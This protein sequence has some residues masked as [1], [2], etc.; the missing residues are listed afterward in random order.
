[1]RVVHGSAA[2]SHRPRR[3]VL[4]IGNFDGVHIGHRAILRTVTDRARVLDGEAVVYTFDPH[5]RKVLQGAAA[6]ALLTT[7]EQKLELL[8]AAQI[9][10]VVLE[11][12]TA[13]FARTPPETFVRENIHARMG[14]LEVYVG[15]DFHYGRDREGSMR[16]LTELGPRLGFAVTIIPEV[17]MGSR[18][19]SSSR[20]RALLAEGAVE[21]AK[22]LLG[23]SY[24]VRGTVVAGDRRGRTLGFPTANLAPETEILPA[25]GVYAGR[26]RLL[27]GGSDPGAILGAVTNVGRRPTFKP[28]DPPLAE[29]H[30]L[31]WSG[32]LYGRRI[33]LTFETRLREE[34]RFSGP[35]ALREQIARDVAEGRRRLEAH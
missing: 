29:A 7:T 20:I 6:P 10:L 18:D 3:P 16:L 22:L 13:A 34:R 30:L 23:R 14:P 9:D 8:A 12:F 17:T 5:P 1:M 35:D 4:T 31:D 24:A 19:V 33:E 26:A 11:P 15:Y 21:E 32:D 28:D 2:L 25:S 27:D